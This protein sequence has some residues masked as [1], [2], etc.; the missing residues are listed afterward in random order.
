MTL[1]PALLLVG[2][3]AQA[4]TLKEQYRDENKDLICVYQSHF[5]R[6]AVNVGFNGHCSFNVPDK[7]L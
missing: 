2:W 5:K 3:S 1:I 7:G 4:A 6:I